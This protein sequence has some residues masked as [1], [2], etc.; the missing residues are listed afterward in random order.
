MSQPLHC[1]L[2]GLGDCCVW[3]WR[4]DTCS[5][6]P[7]LYSPDASITS[8]PQLWQP[9]MSLEGAKRPLWGCCKNRPQL[10]ATD[11]QWEINC[12]ESQMLLCRKMTRATKLPRK[13]ARRA[14]SQGK[15]SYQKR[16]K[17]WF[18]YLV[19]LTWNSLTLSRGICL[20][21]VTLVGP[22]ELFPL[23]PTLTN[24]SPLIST[25]SPSEN[26][27]GPL[28]ECSLNRPMTLNDT[29]V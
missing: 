29:G 8:L 4:H 9:K 1:W 25:F 23:L 20:W 16:K 21:T 27:C 19:T 7:G 10:R 2:W 18:K 6:I 11:L 5:S 12:Q 22:C 15:G 17:I 13:V 26:Q 24:G 3:R 28:C 14:G